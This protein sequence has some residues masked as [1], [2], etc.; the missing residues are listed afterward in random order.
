ME[1]TTHAGAILIRDGTLMPPSLQIAGSPF[2]AGWMQVEGLDGYSLERKIR[3]AGWTF[4]CFAG[5]LKA[6]FFG[7]SKGSRLHAAINRILKNSGAGRFNSLEIMRLDSK[8][9]L[10]L[11]YTTVHA[12]SCHIQ[13]GMILS[14][15]KDAHPRN[16]GEA[17]GELDGSGWQRGVAGLPLEEPGV[18]SSAAV[19]L[20]H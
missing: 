9:F 12:R 7:T 2:V 18:Q 17:S 14:P 16:Q 3:T 1:D 20:N 10:G 8:K 15:A 19:A 6:T 11:P 13:Q 5:E 4:F